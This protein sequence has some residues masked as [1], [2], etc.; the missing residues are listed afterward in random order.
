[1]GIWEKPIFD[2]NLLK[3]WLNTCVSG[4]GFGCA[5]DQGIP[6]PGF[7]AVDV[8]RKCIMFLPTLARYAAFSYTSDTPAVGK[9]LLLNLGNKQKYQTLKDEDMPDIIVDVIRLCRKLGEQYL[10]V[11]QLC[12]AQDCPEIK[13]LQIALMD[14]IHSR[15]AFATVITADREGH[16][17]LSGLR[18]RPR[19]SF[20]Y[21]TRRGV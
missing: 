12:I 11:D 13:E 3:S 15:A 10:W 16:S 8:R 14:R 19:N 6:P 21:K 20:I 17:G 1:V 18:K 7:I 2:V 9:R 5:V 4:H